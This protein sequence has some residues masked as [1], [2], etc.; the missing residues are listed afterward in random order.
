[1]RKLSRAVEQSPASIVITDLAGKIEYVNARF[2]QVTGYSPAEVI[3]QN[4]RLLKTDQTPAKTHQQLWAT[5]Q[6]GQEWHGEFVNRKK[7]GSP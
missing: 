7:D 3:G 1:M 6:A 4:P 2:C 5:L